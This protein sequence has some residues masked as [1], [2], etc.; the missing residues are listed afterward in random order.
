MHSTLE[1]FESLQDLQN[2]M[3]FCEDVCWAFLHSFHFIP[4]YIPRRHIFYRISRLFIPRF[5]SE[6]AQ[7]A[8]SS[9]NDQPDNIIIDKWMPAGWS[10]AP[11][12][13]LKMKTKWVW[14]LVRDNDCATQ[15]AAARLAE[16]VKYMKTLRAAQHLDLALPSMTEVYPGY[17]WN[18]DVL[19]LALDRIYRM[20]DIVSWEQS[21][22]AKIMICIC[23]PK[24]AF[25]Q[26]DWNED[27]S[28][29]R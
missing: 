19:P 5:S 1:V 29:I 25:S 10:T 22:T 21:N 18:H 11:W 3:W 8:A 9:S 12:I 14:S 16:I 24:I 23:K 4:T 6:V 17:F 26:K 2:C 7:A 20:A 28:R 15:E 27:I 13:R